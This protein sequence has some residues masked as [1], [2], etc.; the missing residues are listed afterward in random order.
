MR[1]GFFYVGSKERIKCY[2]CNGGIQRF[3]PFNKPFEEHAKWFLGCEF[4]LRTLGVNMGNRINKTIMRKAR[5][6]EKTSIADTVRQAIR[7]H[8]C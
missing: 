4:I 5:S 3:G 8:K 2:G 6:V 1:A 7:L